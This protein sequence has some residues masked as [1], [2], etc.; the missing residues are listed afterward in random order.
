MAVVF[1]S[2]NLFLLENC[3]CQNDTCFCLVCRRRQA[4][5]IVGPLRGKGQLRTFFDTILP[6]AREVRAEAVFKASKKQ[7]VHG[8]VYKEECLAD[9]TYKY[10]KSWAK[11]QPEYQP[12][13][14]ENKKAFE[15][16]CVDVNEAAYCF[17]KWE[18]I[19]GNLTDPRMSSIDARTFSVSKF[20]RASNIDWCLEYNEKVRRKER[21]QGGLPYSEGQIDDIFQHIVR[22]GIFDDIDHDP[23]LAAGI[24]DRLQRKMTSYCRRKHH[25][26]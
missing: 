23:K 6:L 19:V 9:N 3:R 12:L 8:K 10:F 20:Y 7:I 22:S 4:D 17:D 15:R 1:G 13:I 21:S 24:G 14:G 25:P 2:P 5:S 26:Y 11:N 16:H 18:L